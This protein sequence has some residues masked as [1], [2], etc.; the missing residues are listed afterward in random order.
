MIKRVEDFA[1]NMIIN[2]FNAE[3][4]ASLAIE[5]I[6]ECG[7]YDAGPKGKRIEDPKD[8]TDDQITRLAATLNGNKGPEGD[9]DD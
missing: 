9:F 2:V 6:L 7:S 3:D 1:Y 8:W 4:T 5:A